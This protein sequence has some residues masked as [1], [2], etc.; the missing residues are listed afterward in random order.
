MNIKG[1]SKRFPTGTCFPFG[2]K[3]FL[4]VNH[5]ILPCERIGHQHT[6]G[7][8]TPG[9]VKLDMDRVT[10]IYNGHYKKI[11]RLCRSC[12]MADYCGQC[13]LH[14]DLENDSA[15]CNS[16]MT[17]DDRKNHLAWNLSYLE[18]Y[19][20]ISNRIVKEVVRE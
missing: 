2:K 7:S 17:N 4:T 9:G 11:A 19:S 5:K 1:E 18:E 13:M 14:L 10:K 15:T 8:V 20:K 3:I 12:Y 16:F 6:L